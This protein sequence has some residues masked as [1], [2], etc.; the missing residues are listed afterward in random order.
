MCLLS[1]AMHTYTKYA[2]T[3]TYTRHTLTAIIGSALVVV[4]IQ[5]AL[6]GEGN[7]PI[8]YHNMRC[9]GSEPTLTKCPHSSYTA[10]CDH[11]QDV[12]VICLANS[13][14]N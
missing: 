11:S 14:Y 1:V 7:G 5:E 3:L 13:E 9:N 6:F 10:S 4:P 12:G 8:Q 2:C